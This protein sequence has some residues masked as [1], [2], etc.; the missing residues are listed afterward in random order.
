MGLNPRNRPAEASDPENRNGRRA[1]SRRNPNPPRKGSP[2]PHH[3]RR[4]NA[5]TAA[6]PDAASGSNT[7]TTQTTRQGT[8][9]RHPTAA[10]DQDDRVHT[11]VVAGGR[12]GQGVL[13]HARRRGGGGGWL[14]ERFKLLY[15]LRGG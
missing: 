13:P 12:T 7:Q 6:G 8:S 11:E 1:P 10:E 2:R 4:A 5:Y 15:G 3:H 14:R 9:R